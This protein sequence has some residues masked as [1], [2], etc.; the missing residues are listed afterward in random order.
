MKKF[1]PLFYSL[2][3]IC[4]FAIAVF[5]CKNFGYGLTYQVT[6][7]LPKGIYLIYP[8]KNI[9][10]GDIVI[11]YPPNN[12]KI[13]LAKNK[14]APLSNILMKKVVGMPNDFVCNKDSKVIV[15]K[16]YFGKMYY[17]YAKG[18]RMPYVSFC[19]K[20]Q[21]EQYL[22]LSNFIDRSYDGRYFGPVYR[23]QII[24]KAKKL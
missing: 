14:W 16:K 2:I 19:A 4:L 11:F 12:A 1:I 9:N 10:R 21:S 24:A 22:L 13:F 7:S 8:T 23:N 20:L 5:L 3:I 17:F 6:A 18:K 15:N